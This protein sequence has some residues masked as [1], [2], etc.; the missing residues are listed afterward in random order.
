M[1]CLLVYHILMFGFSLGLACSF[2]VLIWSY[3]V[4]SHKHTLSS[5][6]KE[7]MSPSWGLPRDLCYRKA[8][9]QKDIFKK[10]TGKS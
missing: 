9:C 8:I 2:M 5:T 4:A 7:I 3:Y 6:K 1:P 10:E